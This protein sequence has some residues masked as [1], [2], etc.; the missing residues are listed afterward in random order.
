YDTPDRILG[1]PAS[2]F[3]ADFVGADRGLKRLSVTPIEQSGLISPPRLAHGANAGDVRRHVNGTAPHIALV[4]D[5]GGRVVGWID[6]EAAGD[7]PDDGPIER[8][9]RPID[10]R[11]G[12]ES[13]LRDALAELMLA[14]TGW[15]AVVDGDDAVLGVLTA[16]AIQRAGR[17]P[18]AA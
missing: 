18:R 6:R 4:E 3:V 2:D 16:D 11:V 13:T 1:S 9:V 17:E 10:V 5:G 15:I 12:A 14:D 8:F 7:A